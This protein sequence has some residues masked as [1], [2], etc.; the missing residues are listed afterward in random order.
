MKISEMPIK[1]ARNILL[2]VTPHIT[3]ILDEISRI[4][5]MR[6]NPGE[7]SEVEASGRGIE[8]IKELISMMLD[9]QYENV[10]AVMAAIYEMK[11][12]DFADLTLTE[13]T[14]KIDET[15]KDELLMRF[16]PALQRMGP[17]T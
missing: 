9:T 1:K 17:K 4:N 11:P 14:D 10:I 16:F 12:D 15:L 13:V 3:A 6:A 8:I 5:K 2:A 7:L